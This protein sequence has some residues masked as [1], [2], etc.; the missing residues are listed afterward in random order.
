MI[1][2][3]LIII[4]FLLAPGL[5]GCIEKEDAKKVSFEEKIEFSPVAEN[6]SIR[7]GV[8]AIVSPEK[9]FVNY[10]EIFDYI[11][12]K[13]GRPVKLV[14]RKTYYEMNELV[15]TGYVSAAFICSTAYVEGHDSSGMELLVIP[16]VN[17]KTVYYSYT[18][19][20]TD[21]DIENFEQLR[22]RSFAF[23]DPLSNSGYLVPAYYLVMINE[24]PDSFFKSYIFTYSHDRSIEVVAEKLVDAA[25]VDSLIWDYANATDPK[26]TSK[27]KI[28]KKSQQYGMSPVVVP[29][30]L[31]PELKN[32]LREVLLRMHEDEK[33][34]AILSRIMIDKFILGDDADYNS[35]REMRARV[36]AYGK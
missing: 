3:V 19:V 17:G 32:K 22:G 8:A 27:T 2:T 28:I 10:Q 31:D 30:D 4:L 35:I 7:I 5:V 1:K 18:I 16:V 34:R 14:Q 25:N 24:T 9:T 23:S 13:I 33:G 29:K 15:K 36:E 11:S 6:E 20:A 21:S 12:E 26:F